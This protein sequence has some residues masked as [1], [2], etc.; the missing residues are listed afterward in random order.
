MV[1]E[2][3]EHDWYSLLEVPMS[4]TEEDISRAFRQ[5]AR[6]HHPDRNKSDPDAGMLMFMMLST[7]LPS[8]FLTQNAE[9]AR[10]DEKLTISL[11][12]LLFRVALA[13]IGCKPLFTRHILIPCFNSNKISAN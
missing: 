11:N 13:F 1:D 9:E 10:K 12:L 5:M 2:I 6:I 3:D 8:I 4:A 7:L